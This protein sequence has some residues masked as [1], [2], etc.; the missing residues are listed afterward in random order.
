M[1]DLPPLIPGEVHLWTADLNAC[2]KQAARL[3]ALLSVAERD[4]YSRIL[5]PV[6][7]EQ[8]LLSRAI[9]R[10]I[11]ARYTGGNPED[12][13]LHTAQGG[14]P[15]LPDLSLEFNISH[16]SSLFLCGVSYQTQIGVDIQE[17]YPLSGLRW[18]LQNYFSPVEQR[19]LGS[20]SGASFQN[21]L[22]AIWTAKES[23]LK[24]SGAGFRR[25]PG[26]CSLL[27]DLSNS[28]FQLIDPCGKIQTG[29]EWT[30]IPVE[31]LSGYKAALTMKGK[32][33][34]FLSYRF[35]LDVK[36]RNAD[37]QV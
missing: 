18:I 22:F 14:K 11:L 30:I 9:L 24:A 32:G 16:S 20:L 33:L 13:I 2:R 26:G 5:S 31:T 37:A 29:S 25:S 17:V 6:K 3:Q 36:E 15:F 19:Y 12:L 34:K 23:Y 10:L 28:K 35:N 21:A 8:G 4:R 7:A 27:P 1:P